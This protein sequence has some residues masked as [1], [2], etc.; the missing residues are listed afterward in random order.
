[1]DKKIL[2]SLCM[3]VKNESACIEGVLNSVGNFPDEIIIVDTGSTD[4][5]KELVRKFT[6]K[7]YD[8]KWNDNFSDARNFSFSKAKGEYIIWLDA[9]DYISNNELK[10]LIE[11]K[12]NIN[13]NIDIFM[14][15]YQHFDNKNPNPNFE[16]YRE[17]IIRNDSRYKWAG[18][19]HECINLIGNI[20]YLDIAIEHKRGEKSDPKRNLKIYEQLIKSGK[21]LNTREVYYYAREL[22]D[23]GK[24]KKSIQWINKFLKLNDAWI[25]DKIGAIEIKTLSYFMLNEIDKAQ[26]TLLNSLKITIPRAN[27]CCLLAD[28]FMTQ[29]VLYNAIYWYKQAINCQKNNKNGFVNNDYFS[30]YPNIKLVICY[31]DLGNLKNAKVCNDEALKAKPFDYY[32]LKNKEFFDSVSL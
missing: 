10:K 12:N 27:I 15:K 30:Y 3:I 5:T 9:D 7:I 29:N 23:N 8:F 2:I 6:N 25:E 17:R 18:A 31:Y 4:N 14:V 11:F 26:Q 1:M 28:T 19:V 24:Y 32:A 21:Q 16:F 20:E 22:Y 13:K